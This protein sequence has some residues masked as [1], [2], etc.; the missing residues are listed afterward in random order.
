MTAAALDFR[1]EVVPVARLAALEREALLSLMRETYQGVDPAAFFRDLDEKQE[2]ILLRQGDGRICGFSAV[3]SWE[4]DA[5]DGRQRVVFFGD[6]VVQTRAW[7]S[8][9]FPKAVISVLMGQ[10]LRDRSVPTYCLY[11][12]AG[13]R[14]YHFM[15]FLCRDCYPRVQSSTPPDIQALLDAIATERYGPDFDAARG[16]VRFREG[17]YALRNAKATGAAARRPWEAFFERRNPGWPAGEELVCLTRITEENL[18]AAAL[19]LW[20]RP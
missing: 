14:T 10:A 9:A 20:S 2:A 8:P 7:G 6:T 17:A 3:K 5:E 12:C 19:R 4:R 1:H 16:V 15:L 13:A 11:L 18:T